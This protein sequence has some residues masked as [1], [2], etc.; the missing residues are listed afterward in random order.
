MGVTAA[1]GMGAVQPV[2]KTARHI[3]RNL[4]VIMKSSFRSADGVGPYGVS[5][6]AFAKHLRVL[7]RLDGL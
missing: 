5:R 2:T 1:S 7:Y 4:L 3:T 6:A